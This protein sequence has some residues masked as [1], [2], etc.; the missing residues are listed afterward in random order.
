MAF[1]NLLHQRLVFKST[2]FATLR[3]CDFALLDR[4]VVLGCGRF[5]QALLFGDNI[6]KLIEL[7]FSALHLLAHYQWHLAV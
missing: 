7:V 1:Y 3:F 2:F 4:L 6:V 5:C